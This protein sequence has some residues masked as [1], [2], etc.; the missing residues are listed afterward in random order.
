VE[1]PG[2]SYLYTLATVSIT[3]VGLSVFF[4][5]IRQALGRTMS[6]FDIFLTRNFLQL[7]FTVTV[8]ALLA[9]LLSLLDVRQ[10]YIWRIAS[11]ISAV[12]PC[13]VAL[14]YPRRR[15]AATGTPMPK[16]ASFSVAAIFVAGMILLGNA[17]GWPFASGAGLHACGLTIVLSI[18]FLAF[19]HA[20]DRVLEQTKRV[21]DGSHSPAGGHDVT[22]TGHPHIA[23]SG[24]S[25]HGP[26][27]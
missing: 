1:L 23:A 11:M 3:F 21:G 9:P 12:P 22:P 4:I 8:C 14:T 2:A 6:E 13:L 19:L 25:R 26:P 27:G 24:G 17:F 18:S 10:A 20:L 15:F 7:G 16:V 5:L